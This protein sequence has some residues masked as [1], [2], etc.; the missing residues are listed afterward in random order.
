MDWGDKIIDKVLRMVLYHRCT[1]M[2]S[3]KINVSRFE[4][5]DCYLW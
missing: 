3:K 1:E 2:E 4:P 5:P